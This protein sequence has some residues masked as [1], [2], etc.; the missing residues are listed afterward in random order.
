MKTR[1]C[2]HQACLLQPRRFNSRSRNI[3]MHWGIQGA[4]MHVPSIKRSDDTHKRACGT[5]ACAC[6]FGYRMRDERVSG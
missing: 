3:P 1:R 2:R 5:R 4:R 6:A